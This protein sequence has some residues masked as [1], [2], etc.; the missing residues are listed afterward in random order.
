[1]LCPYS[2]IMKRLRALIEVVK[3]PLLW[4]TIVLLQL[5]DA[6]AYILRTPIK[7][8]DWHIYLVSSVL[9]IIFIVWLWLAHSFLP[10]TL[11][12]FSAALI[13]AILAFLAVANLLVY[14]EMGD[15]LSLY[16]LTFIQ[17]DPQYFVNFATSYFFTLH[18]LWGAVLWGLL[19][20]LWY[21]RLTTPSPRVSISMLLAF[22]LQPAL[23]LVPLNY[24]N[25]HGRYSLLTSTAATGLAIRDFV[26]FS[27]TPNALY[28]AKHEAVPMLPKARQSRYNIV[29]VVN[30][31]WGVH[32]LPCYGATTSSMPFFTTWLHRDSSH[33]FVFQR[34]YTNSSATDVSIPSLFTGVSPHESSKK[35]HSMPFLWDWAKAA[36]MSTLFVSAQRYSWSQFDKFFFTPGPDVYVTAEH[37]DAP[38]INDTGVDELYAAYRFCEELKRLPRDTPF[39]AIYNSNALHAPF[40]Q[41]SQLLP[42]QPSFATPYDNAAA[43]V[44]KSFEGIYTTLQQMGALENTIFV[45]TS[46]HGE[47]HTNCRTCTPRI[48]AFNK[49]IM[50]IPF[51]VRVPKEWMEHNPTSAA[52]LA[53]NTTQPVAN[54]DIAPTL[55]SLLSFNVS[56]EHSALLQQFI[57]FPLT[58]PLPDNRTIIALNTNDIRSWE[59]EGFSLY[60]QRAHFHFSSVTGPLYYD[61]TRDNVE[62]TNL[63]YS[64]DSTRRN[65]ILHTIYSTKHLQRIYSK[66]NKVAPLTAS[67]H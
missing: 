33:F 8:F 61:I 16:M 54:I 17:A 49:T 56:Q 48:M 57:G 19:F 29:L 39:F 4:Y 1:M 20:T 5:L 66:Y 40:Q 24:L 51:F 44:D 30:E 46:D 45:F 55:A 42:V 36:G 21:P 43:L 41:H 62:T 50:N 52:A 60:T 10:R 35:L 25:K 47:Y 58:Q 18:T 7:S 31:S 23:Y 28:A 53:A 6:F 26:R 9:H 27:A 15:Y 2:K 37:M 63:W 11:R 3:Q 14:R 38:Q 34:A 32:G 64:L 13:S 12:V 67:K 22:L 59:H 65:S